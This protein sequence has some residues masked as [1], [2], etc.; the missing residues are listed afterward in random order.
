MTPESFKSHTI[1]GTILSRICKSMLH[2]THGS[3][4]FCRTGS[5]ISSMVLAALAGSNNRLC[6]HGRFDLY[7]CPHEGMAEGIRVKYRAE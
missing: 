5:L 1:Q 6:A 2:L 7:R 4:R 3:C